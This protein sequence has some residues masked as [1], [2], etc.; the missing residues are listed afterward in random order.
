LILE[1][2][3]MTK[4]KP[5]LTPLAFYGSRS[6]QDANTAIGKWGRGRGGQKE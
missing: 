6:S 3:R 5:I 1:K 4:N 2:E